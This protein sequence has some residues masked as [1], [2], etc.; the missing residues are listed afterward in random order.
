VLDEKHGEEVVAR[1]RL[2]KELSKTKTMLLKEF[3]EHDTLRITI[4]LVLND[5]EMT[6][7]AGTSLHAVQVVDVMDRVCGMAKR[8]LHLGLQRS[9]AIMCSHY[10]NIDLHVMSQGFAP[11]YDDAELDQIEEEVA[12]LAQVL[13]A[14]MEEVIVPE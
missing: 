1:C 2:K 11:S 10:K 13:A 14:N 6:S 9:F 3:D 4:S 12:P 7:E 8:A 5:F